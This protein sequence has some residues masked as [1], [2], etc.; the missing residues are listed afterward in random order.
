M[1]SLFRPEALAG[2]R[3]AW[4]G[5]ILLIRPLSLTLLSWLLA[6][7]AAL[8]AAYLVLGHYTRSTQIGGVLAADL[9][10]IPLTPLQAATVLEIHARE[11]QAVRQGD[12]LFVLA[13]SAVVPRDA[14]PMAV[15][16]RPAANAHT[17]PAQAP[18][19]VPSAALRV[20]IRAPQD[21]VFSAV[22]A[23]P[24]QTVSATSVLASLVPAQARLQAE[25]DA[26][27]SVISF[28]RPGQPVLLRY[29]AFPFQRFGHFPGRVLQVSRAPLPAGEEAWRPLST[30]AVGTG[31]GAGGWS[32]V[33][34]SGAPLYR[35]TVALEQ[36]AVPANGQALPLA[37]GMRL[38]ADVLLDRRRL[39]EW[40]FEPVLRHA[41]GA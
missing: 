27:A 34:T 11:G 4:L 28:L 26:P 12:L 23:Q 22:F 31:A 32:G 39:I 29:E 13:A 3:Q 10:A 7:S 37:A 35:V 41:G 36:Q 21:G 17:A 6:G 1:G 38:D 30:P 20:V 16:R 40:L 19:A 15:Q 2:Q 9:Q 24:G 5:S 14:A 18:Q 8:L 25:L 33:Q